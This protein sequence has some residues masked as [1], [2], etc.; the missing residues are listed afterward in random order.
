M[1]TRRWC[2]A[3]SR[4]PWLFISY[5]TSLTESINTTKLRYTISDK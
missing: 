2:S 3:S 1:P 5:G 4:S